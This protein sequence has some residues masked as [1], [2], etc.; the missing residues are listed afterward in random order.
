AVCLLLVIRSPTMRRMGVS[1]TVSLILGGPPGATTWLLEDRS[2][3]SA[4]TLPS[5]PLPLR[6][7]RSMPLSLAIRFAAGDA[8][9][10]VEKSPFDPPSTK[11][12]IGGFGSASRLLSELWV[13]GSGR[14]S[15]PDS[16]RGEGA[17]ADKA[18]TSPG[19]R[20]TAILFPTGMS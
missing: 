6:V 8:S 10:R 17:G 18:P 4:T 14:E 7:A 3:S 5:G 12:E 2:T 15:A 11:G 9:T 20:M 16:I 1:W 13:E 19:A